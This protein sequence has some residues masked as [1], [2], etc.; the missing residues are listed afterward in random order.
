MQARN[1]WANIQVLLIFALVSNFISVAK[2]QRSDWLGTGISN[3]YCVLET[4]RLIATYDVARSQIRHFNPNPDI[5]IS[6]DWLQYSGQ[7]GF[8]V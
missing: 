2:L 1:C 5:L 3:S 6:G 7:G 8:H 4:S